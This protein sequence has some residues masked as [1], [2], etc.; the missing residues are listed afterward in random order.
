VVAAG[1][2]LQRPVGDIRSAASEAAMH[3]SCKEDDLKFNELRG[4]LAVIDRRIDLNGLAADLGR[5]MNGALDYFAKGKPHFASVEHLEFEAQDSAS[6]SKL[7][8]KL[9]KRIYAV[10]NAI[11]HSKSSG[12]RYSPYTDDLELGREVP[13]V[14]IAAEQLLIPPDDRM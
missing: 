8:F 7:G 9:A 11:T 12:R 1:G 6:W 5:Y 13:L 4:L 10:R 3:L 14:R 2:K